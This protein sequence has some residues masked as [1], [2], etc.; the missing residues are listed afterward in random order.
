MN[1]QLSYYTNNTLFVWWHS[2][3]WSACGE[4]SRKLR[5]IE[6]NQTR[7]T[8]IESN[9]CEGWTSKWFN[10]VSTTQTSTRLLHH[11]FAPFRLIQYK[12]SSSF[13]TVNNQL[14]RT[15]THKSTSFFIS[16]NLNNITM[17]SMF[18]HLEIVQC[19]KWGFSLGTGT[20][21]ELSSKPNTKATSSTAEPETTR[22]Y[23]NP[24]PAATTKQNPT[25]LR[26]RFAP[27]LDGIHCFETILPC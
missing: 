12:Y 20:K 19:Q 1:E 4:E 10:C 8:I 22:K 3:M 23:P 21:K 26:P 17:M 13:G 16:S 11:F 7:L 14:S 24:S 9:G 25:R 5:E 6:L 18:S 2:W 15:I 27:E